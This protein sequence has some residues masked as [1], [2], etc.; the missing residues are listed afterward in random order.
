MIAH[1]SGQ[2]PRR[3]GNVTGYPGVFQGNPHPHPSKPVPTSMGA[4]FAKTRGYI[5]RGWVHVQNRQGIHNNFVIIINLLF[6]ASKSTAGDLI[7]LTSKSRD[8][9]KPMSRVRVRQGL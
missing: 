1:S 7:T 8:T 4:G 6:T 5:T 3:V 2:R 9:V